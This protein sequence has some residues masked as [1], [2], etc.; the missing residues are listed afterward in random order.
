MC[1]L[2]AVHPETA[3]SGLERTG[4]ERPQFRVVVNRDEQRTRAEALP[5]R[6]CRAGGTD[7]IFPVDPASRGTWI[8]VNTAGLVLAVLNCNPIHKFITRPGLRS[9]G[10]IVPS[11]LS[12]ESVT[13]ALARAADID[14]SQYP[15]F[16]LVAI[17]RERHA[18]VLGD[19]VTTTVQTLRRFD[20]PMM[21]TSSG[22]GDHVVETPRRE[23]FQSMMGSALARGGCDIV[24][25]QDEFHAHRW[26]ERRHVSVE[27]SRAD[28]RT[29]SR[30][31]VEVFGDSVRLTYRALHE[32]DAIVPMA[33]RDAHAEAHRG[34]PMR[35]SAIP[36]RLAQGSIA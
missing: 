28:A 25:R 15:P 3:R 35:A 34:L 24:D 12:C 27:M 26:P 4:P 11:L 8:G 7:A 31:V 20:G 19:G 30:T 21:V 5:P 13:E 33:G 29:V 17:E 6:V 1:T 10:D 23:L 9:R 32:I 14:A 2:T 18:V 22:L 36:A 16:R